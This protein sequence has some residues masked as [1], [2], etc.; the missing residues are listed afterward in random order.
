MQKEEAPEGSTTAGGAAGGGG[1]CIPLLRVCPASLACPVL[2]AGRDKRNNEKRTR[3][4]AQGLG[5][6]AWPSRMSARG[7]APEAWNNRSNHVCQGWLHPILF[8]PGLEILQ[9]AQKF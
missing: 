2:P 8:G 3:L 7:V 1:R 4:R 5:S 6:E 9:K